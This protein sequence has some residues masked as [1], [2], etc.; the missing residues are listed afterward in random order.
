MVQHG[1]LVFYGGLIGG[2]GGVH[3]LHVAQENAALEGGGRAGAEHRAGERVRTDRLP[4][5]R[6]LLRQAH[7][8]ELGDSL[9]GLA[10]VIPLAGASDA[11]LRFLLN[12]ALYLGLAWFYRRRKFDGQVFAIYLMCYAVTRSFVEIYRG[13]YTPQ[14][15]FHGWVTPAQLT[16]V[17]E[18]LLARSFCRC[19]RG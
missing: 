18:L 1:G 19:C 3:Y 5:E 8:H 16:G 7:D 17:V 12:L 14:H 9:S 2:V 4:D 6:L 10:R 13:D 11:G 15:L